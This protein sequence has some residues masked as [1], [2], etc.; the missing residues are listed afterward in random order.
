MLFRS[1]EDP[2]EPPSFGM[3]TRAGGGY[4]PPL[5]NSSSKLGQKGGR[6]VAQD[7]ETEEGRGEWE[8]ERAVRDRESGQNRES[9]LQREREQ[10]APP[11]EDDLEG[12]ALAGAVGGEAAALLEAE[13]ERAAATVADLT[14]KHVFFFQ[15][16]AVV[17][18]NLDE[19]EQQFF[20]RFIED[21][22]EDAV[23]PEEQERDDMTF[24]YAPRSLDGEV[25]SPTRLYND[26]VCLSSNSALEKLSVSFALAQSTKLMIL[27]TRVDTTFAENR[28]YPQELA[29]TGRI[30]LSQV[31]V[32]Q[33]IGQLFIVKSSVNLESDMLSIPDFFWENEV[34]EP[35]YRHATKYLEMDQRVVV[36][37]KQLEVLDSMLYMLKTQLEKRHATR[38]EWI[39]IW[40][41][42]ATIGL[43]LVWDV[44]V[45]DIWG[46][47]RDNPPGPH[48]PRGMRSQDYMTSATLAPAAVPVTDFLLASTPALAHAASTL[49]SRV[50]PK[51]TSWHAATN[52]AKAPERK[53]F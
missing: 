33:Q 29:E 45:K 36:V 2:F 39:V 51:V 9:E 40:L 15:Y 30:S 16:G 27:E 13:I 25:T 5:H 10:R 41:L 26:Q 37:N 53:D 14:T 28:A 24:F 22:E 12:E 18:W 21:F 34:W 38:L 11:Q 7:S 3:R 8:M 42:V 31:Q 50:T 6:F 1:E 52:S 23:G 47:F 43:K 49:A 20:L 4:E 32:A 46:F 48:G 35:I 19:A 17:F 44:L